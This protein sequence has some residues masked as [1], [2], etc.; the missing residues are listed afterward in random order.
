VMRPGGLAP[1]E[2]AMVSGLKPG[3]DAVLARTTRPLTYEE[4]GETLGKS[5]AVIKATMSRY[6]GEYQ[7]HDPIRPQG[8]VRFSLPHSARL[9]EPVG[10]AAGGNNQGVTEGVTG[11]F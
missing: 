11:L 9:A 4:I 2:L 10:V 7:S 6:R 8:P 5:K 1:L 3:I